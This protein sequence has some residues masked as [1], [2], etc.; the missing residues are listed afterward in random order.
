MVR[1]A[2]RAMAK[3]KVWPAKESEVPLE[4]VFQAEPEPDVDPSQIEAL[5]KAG[6][7]VAWIDGSKNLPP[8]F[9]VNYNVPTNA[10]LDQLRGLPRVASVTLGDTNNVG[11]KISITDAGLENL[12]G[13]DDLV[14]LA[15][16]G[17]SKVTDVGLEHLEGLTSLKYLSINSSQ[18][19]DA[20]LEHLTGLTNLRTLAFF[21]SEQL[22]DAG[23]KHI[24]GLPNL[25][26]LTFVK[27][28]VTDAAVDEL[29]QSLPQCRIT[30]F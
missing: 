11:K 19:T 28:Q 14:T 29:S 18:I 12:K 13:M 7:E 2:E 23:L 30:K 4:D 15:I 10:G 21:N 20:G 22:T 9:S 1:E 3:M 25:K 26:N 24:E 27:T 6:V 8:G 16:S 17:S 5:K